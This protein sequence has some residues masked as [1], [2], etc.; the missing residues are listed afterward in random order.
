MNDDEIHEVLL[1]TLGDIAPETDPSTLPSGASLRDELDLDSMDF[2]RFVTALHERLGVDVPEADYPA[3]D[4]ID[5]ALAY[6]R[7]KRAA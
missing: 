1:S 5:G 7:E 6:L 4:S 3:L 2:L